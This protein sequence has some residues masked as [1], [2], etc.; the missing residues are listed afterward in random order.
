MCKFRLGVIQM[1]VLWGD[2][3]ANLRTALQFIERA[4]ACGADAVCLPELFNTGYDYPLISHK[5]GDLFS[6]GEQVLKQAA[7]RHSLYIITGSM[8]GYCNGRLYNT[9]LLIDPL[10]DIIALYRKIHLFSPLGEPEY[11]TAGKE[12]T[13]AKTALGSWGIMLCYD[14]RFAELSLAMALAGAQ[15][16]F[17]PAQFPHPRRHHW[18]ILLQGRAIENQLYVVGVNRCGA[19]KNCDYFGASMVVDPRGKTIAK[20][21]E[22]EELLIIDIDFKENQQA[23]K[24]LYY[25][26]DRRGALYY[27]K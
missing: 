26:G 19:D 15:I 16:I 6:R 18:E 8:A 14:L 21:G 23:R 11:F 3:E 27:N 20:A 17:V 1:D 10:G 13:V 2:S 7:L 5:A 12:I 9:S 4:A 25:L 22:K 24:S